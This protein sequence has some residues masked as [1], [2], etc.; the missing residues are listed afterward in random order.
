MRC[1]F[2]VLTLFGFLQSH[3]LPAFGQTA[4][5]PDAEL[6]DLIQRKSFDYFVQERD[7]GTGLVADQASNF[8]PDGHPTGASIAATGFGLA[9]YAVGVERGWISRERALS[10]T[11]QTLQFFYQT[12]EH[13]RGFFYHFLNMKT[14]VRMRNSELSPIDTALLLAGAFFAA[15]YF[16]DHAVRTLVRKIYERIDWNW[17]RNGAD[18]LSLS[19][20]PE[21]GFNRRHW[22]HYDESILMYL[23]AIASPTHPIP[24]SSWHAI[25]RPVGSYRD[26]RLIQMPPLFTHQYPQIF[27][28]FRNQN[29]GYADYFKN[30]VNATLANRA[31]CMDQSSAY[32]TYGPD[33]W[34]LTA[35]EGPSGYRAYGAP[36]GWASHDGT[37]APTGCGS[38]IVFT[39]NE[40][41]ACLRNLYEKYGDRLWGKYGFSDAFNLDKN[42]FSQMAFGINQGPL[43]LMIENHRTELLW[44]VMKRIDFL[45]QAMEKVGF[46]PGTMDLPWPDPPVYEA[47]YLPGGIQVDAYMKDWPNSKAIELD[48]TFREIG[49]LTDDEDLSATV[50][51]GWDERALYFVADITD[52]S[53]IARKYGKDIWM[54]DLFEIY[55][56]PHGDGLHWNSPRDFQIGFRPTLGN[57]A[58]EVWSWFQGD[59]ASAFSGPISSKGFVHAKGYLLEGAVRW[60]FLDVEPQPDRALRVSVAVN[61]IDRDRS[62]AKLQWFFRNEKDFQRFELGKVILRK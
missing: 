12:A 17:M 25:A 36:P 40:S 52:D 33:T 18:T 28:D 22:A 59:T 55:I 13:E 44:D 26:Y 57:D 50:R 61:D 56:D 42:W 58:V 10:M 62:T 21:Q 4:G 16:D 32:S 11:R 8:E 34:G 2:T 6:L 24:V 46:K 49:T 14:G 9:A 53:V 51:F 3:S 43:L 54:D 47:I 60:E 23:M 7:P 39:P 37:V 45:Q 29:D 15:E 5:L 38:S 31:F 19:W 41:M 20:S 35:C 48:R 30:S 1:F 27:F